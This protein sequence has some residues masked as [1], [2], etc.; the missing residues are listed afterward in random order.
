MSQDRADG[1]A[2]NAAQSA[3]AIQDV[4]RNTKTQTEA[5]SYTTTDHDVIRTWAQARGG[6]P[7]SVEGT[8]SG[9][10]DAGVLRIE[11]RDRDEDLAEVDWEPFFRTFDDRALAFVYQ[12]DTSD[13]ALSRFNKFVRRDRESAEAGR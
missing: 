1:R 12:E 4:Q 13:G 8:G 5:A 2:S 11:F 9:D 10:E 6:V 3:D 7:A